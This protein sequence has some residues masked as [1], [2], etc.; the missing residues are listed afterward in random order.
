ML[1]SNASSIAKALATVGIGAGQMSR[2]DFFPHPPAAWKAK[3]ASA[4]RRRRERKAGA[5]GLGRRLG[6]PSF[7]SPMGLI[8]A[9]EAGATA[10]HPSPGGIRCAITM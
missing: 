9:A 10:G 5:P 3:E 2:V 8:A 1:K 4:S 7:P 6:W